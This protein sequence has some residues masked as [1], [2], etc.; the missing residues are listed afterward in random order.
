MKAFLVIADIASLLFAIWFSAALK[1]DAVIRLPE[2]FLNNFIYIGLLSIVTMLASF[3]FFKIYKRM[4]QYFIARDYADLMKAFAIAKLV[5]YTCFSFIWFEYTR[6]FITWAFLDAV[7]SFV[8]IVA[9]RGLVFIGY[10]LWKKKII[11]EKNLEQGKKKKVMII[12]AGGAAMRLISELKSATNS[13]RYTVVALI[14]DS[15]RKQGEMLY[16]VKVCG[17]RDD[18]VRVAKELD[19]DEIYFAVPSATESTKKDILEICNKTGCV[20]KTLPR[21]TAIKENQN[22]E[23]QL[24]KVDYTDL[25]GREQIKPDLSGAFELLKDKTVL[26]TGGGGSIGGELVRQIVG[27]G[28]AKNVI[29]FEIAENGAYEI[30]QELRRKYPEAKLTVLIGSVRDEKRL[31]EVFEEYRPDVV[32]HA[33]AHKHVP[34]MEDSPK[35]AVKNNVYGTFNLAK[36]A[37]K[38]GVKRFVMISTDKAV[39]PTNVMGATKR[40]CEMIVQSFNKKSNTDFVAVRFGNVLGSNGS[41]IP[42]FKEQIESGGPVTVTHP[43]IIRYFMLIP[44]AVSLVLQAGANAK[45]GEIFI[46]DMG[47]PVKIRE[48]AE[49][50]IRLSGHIPGEDIEIKYTGLRD[51]EK[52]YEELLISEEGIQKTESNLIYVARPMEFDS[53]KLFLRLDEMKKDIETASNKEIVDV[54]KELVPT[55]TPNNTAYNGSEK[56]KETVT[57]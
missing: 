44:E 18:I 56:E 46:L 42:L 10:Y 34:L 23:N 52:L 47:S 55:F 11:A 37:D 48:L 32:Y 51:G 49:N 29:I 12:G 25:L 36:T 53:E 35:E 14:D 1:F 5:T 57:V 31:C 9:T 4:W 16:G 26:V 41:V 20:L 24:R 40:I 33:A 3:F 45:G 21:I 54:I 13:A 38:Y 30:Q 27:S 22:I 7:I 8:W 2:W 50:L 17:G 39:N 19:V 6:A 15:K 43:D 28:V